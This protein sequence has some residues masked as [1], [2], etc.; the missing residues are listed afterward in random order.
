MGITQ[1]DRCLRSGADSV[2]EATGRPWDS[3]VKPQEIKC[4]QELLGSEFTIAGGNERKPN[5]A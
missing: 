3:T 2:G 1:P 5:V 4:P